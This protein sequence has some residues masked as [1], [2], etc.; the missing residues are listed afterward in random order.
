M[1][2]IVNKDRIIDRTKFQGSMDGVTYT[3]IFTIDKTL[4]EGWNYVKW[5][6]DEKP[7]F[8]YYKF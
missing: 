4:H 5:E 1:K 2:D 3:T 6:D 7:N 8:R